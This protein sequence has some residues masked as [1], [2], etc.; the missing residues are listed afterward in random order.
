MRSLSI[1]YEEVGELYER[2]NK[3]EKALES[4]GNV[5]HLYE[6]LASEWGKL[7]NLLGLSFSRKSVMGIYE[8]ESR[9]TYALL[10]HKIDWLKA[11][12]SAKQDVNAD[13]K[14]RYPSNCNG[15][16]NDVKESLSLKLS[17]SKIV[18]Y[19]D[20][21]TLACG[22][23]EPNASEVYIPT[24]MRKP[25]R[26]Y[27]ICRVCGTKCDSN[28]KYCIRCGN[29]LCELKKSNAMPGHGKWDSSKKQ[30]GQAYVDGFSAPCGSIGNSLNY[31][32]RTSVTNDEEFSEFPDNYAPVIISKVHFSA[33]A[34]R[35]L[36]KGEYA[37]IDIVMY[38][39]EFRSVVDEIIKKAE[40]PPQETRSGAVRA[41]EG[42]KVKIQLTSPDI[43]IKNNIEEQEWVG[44]YLIYNFAVMLPK[45]YAKGQALFMATVYIDDLI[46]TRLKF[47]AKSWS[48]RQQ[49]IKV[50]QENVLSAFVSYASQDRNRV[51]L[52][53]QGMRKARPDMDI[54]FDVESLRSGE[55]WEDALWTEIDQRDTLFLCWSR[56]AAESPWVSRE[57]KYCYKQK[58]AEAI[59]P[60][61]LEPPSICPPPEELKRKHFNDRLLYLIKV[62]SEKNYY[63]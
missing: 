43:V 6:R 23:E 30:Y 11:K 21:S 60:I 5:L 17:R 63:R 54:F 25:T 4:Y 49:R 8:K 16:K 58:G 24:L 47:V 35:I 31:N 59:E 26:H 1:S 32:Q 57:W 22:K 13:L 48:L 42:A 20:A 2:Q 50:R 51:A 36:T 10:C 19:D 61:P 3:V 55:S 56:N 28:Y 46:A 34:P 62:E 38:Q 37:I 9:N 15:V 33:I 52:I 14:E 41:R 53:V 18:D 12:N 29:R 7:D 27:I 44:D 45:N 39:D 40:T